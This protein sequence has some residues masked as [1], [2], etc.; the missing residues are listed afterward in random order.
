MLSEDS[1]RVT[2]AVHAAAALLWPFRWQHIYLPL[3]P[4]ALQVSHFL[5]EPQSLPL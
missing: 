3:L 4:H 5:Q 2:S 1:D